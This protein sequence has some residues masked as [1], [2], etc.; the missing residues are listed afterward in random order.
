MRED[1]YMANKKVKSKD[2]LKEVSKKE[3]KNN[4]SKE[5]KVRKE[6]LFSKLSNF[7]NGVKLEF[8]RIKWPTKKEMI[9][10]SIA[11]IIFIIC[12]SLFFYLIDIILAGLHSLV[13]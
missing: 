13:K 2:T 5:K 8:K 9:K 12:C 10:Y 7:I 3:N 1:V 6:N 11:T 4:S